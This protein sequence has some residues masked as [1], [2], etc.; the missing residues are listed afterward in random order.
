VATIRDSIRGANHFTQLAWAEA[1]A[2][3]AKQLE[4][5]R[6]S[7]ARAAWR[8]ASA[9]YDAYTEAYWKHMPASRFDYDYAQEAADAHARAHA[10]VAAGDAP[11]LARWIE[12]ALAG[13]FD[14][15]AAA[16]ELTDDLSRAI[17][18]ALSVG[19]YAAGRTDDAER[20]SRRN[21]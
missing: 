15:A 19:C 17:A 4:P 12:D 3:V 2:A 13:R 14:D 10:T 6:P 21:V 9:G 5:A 7:S 18:A 16:A 1:W 20:L 11:P 8:F